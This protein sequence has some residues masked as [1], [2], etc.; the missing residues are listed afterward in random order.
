M[1][2]TQIQNKKIQKNR[3][4]ERFQCTICGT[5]S[6][7][8]RGLSGVRAHVIKYH[9]DQYKIHYGDCYKSIYQ[10]GII[11]VKNKGRPKQ[12]KKIDQNDVLNLLDQ[13]LP[14]LQ[15]D[16]KSEDS[17]LKDPLLEY[18]LDKRVI[19]AFSLIIDLGDPIRFSEQKTHLLI[20]N[21]DHKQFSNL[22]QV[23]HDNVI[24]EEDVTY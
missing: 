15:I 4:N 18:L 16:Q 6:K 23:F 21:F 5:D 22:Q 2:E 17:H 10:D 19:D 14:D 1:E 24:K 3:E 12:H 9:E 7:I 8:Y 13:K 11:P 20:K